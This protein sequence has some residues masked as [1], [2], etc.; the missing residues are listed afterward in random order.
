MSY[1]WTDGEL[2]TAEKLNQTGKNDFIVTVHNI[3]DYSTGLYTSTFDKTPEECLNALAGGATIKIHIT[4]EDADTGE[5]WDDG[6]FTVTQPPID[7]SSDFAIFAKSEAYNSHASYW[8]SS[9][10]VLRYNPDNLTQFT[11]YQEF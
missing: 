6:V 1:T 8:E 10:K 4:H 11:S 9:H 3:Y 5:R 2:I 7:M